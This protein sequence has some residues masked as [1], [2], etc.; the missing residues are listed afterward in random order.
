[1]FK[2]FTHIFRLSTNFSHGLDG[3]KWKLQSWINKCASIKCI[4]K[5][6]INDVIYKQG[7]FKG[8]I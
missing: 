7:A 4:H 5:L 2:V 1:M 3:M 8:S 6:S